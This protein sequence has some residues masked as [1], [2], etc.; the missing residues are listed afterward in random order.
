MKKTITLIVLLLI[1][2]LEIFVL[3]YYHPYITSIEQMSMF[4]M[5]KHGDS[6]IGIEP[7]NIERKD[8]IT[9]AIKLDNKIHHLIK[10]VLGL[11][12]EKI[13]IVA[14]FVYVNNMPIDEHYVLFDKLSFYDE[15]TLGPTEYFVLGDD[16]AISVDSRS[17]GPINKVQITS[18]IIARW[19]L[20]GLK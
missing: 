18:K 2:G 1:L 7:R 8:I 20:F 9:F 14:G 16:R 17:F 6:C 10:R 4:P 5:I 13:K 12:G 11:P 19:N 15:I 3:Y